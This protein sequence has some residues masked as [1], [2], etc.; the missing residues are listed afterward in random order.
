[1]RET[2]KQYRSI[3][4]LIGHALTVPPA[5]PEDDADRAQLLAERADAVRLALDILRTNRD[6][7]SKG[8]F[9]HAIHLLSRI[10]DLFPTA[11]DSGVFRS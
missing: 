2:V 10:H 8:T 4:E 6:R 9:S 5:G 3:V 11:G 1:M 7:G